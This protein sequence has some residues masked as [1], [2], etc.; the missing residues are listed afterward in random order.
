MHR[1]IHIALA[2]LLVLTSQQ[3]ALARGAATGQLAVIC[4]PAGLI[5]VALDDQGQ[6]SGMGH[7]CPD[8]MLALA[9]TAVPPVVLAA[10][11]GVVASPWAAPVAM[12][13]PH[14]PLRHG[15]ARG[16]PALV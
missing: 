6:P 15:A 12:L 8:G 9:S 2:L 14:P 11:Q 16:P 7:Y 3:V 5:A 4:G 13:V 1:L 10:P